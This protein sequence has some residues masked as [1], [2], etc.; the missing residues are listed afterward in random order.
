MPWG[1]S[2]A[3]GP[4]V[5]PSATGGRDPV[6]LASLAARWV[7]LALVLA[8]LLGWFTHPERL[9]LLRR[10]NHGAEVPV[11]DPVAQSM[12]KSMAVPPDLVGRPEASFVVKAEGPSRKKGSGPVQLVAEGAEPRTFATMEELS[13]WAFESNDSYAWLG[14]ALL[15]GSTTVD[16]FRRRPDAEGGTES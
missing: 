13:W 16:T 10:L 4:S 14:F 7:G 15:L 5:S 6:A 2:D 8:H 9:E 1:G 3:G 11:T 12:L